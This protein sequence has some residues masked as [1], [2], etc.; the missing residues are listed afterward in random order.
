[1]SVDRAPVLIK[2]LYTFPFQVEP[3]YMRDV[4]RTEVGVYWTTLYI[5]N[6]TNMLVVTDK[7]L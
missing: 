7:V 5:I 4:D 6:V 3:F 1:M 2:T